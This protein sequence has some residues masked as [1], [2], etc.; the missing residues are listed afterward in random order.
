MI[1]IV[2][3]NQNGVKEM[4]TLFEDIVSNFKTDVSIYN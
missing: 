3:P 4:K 2:E 1:D